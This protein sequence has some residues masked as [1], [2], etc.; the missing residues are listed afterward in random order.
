M[1]Q[2]QMILPRSLLH[3]REQFV[4]LIHERADEWLVFGGQFGEERFEI[5]IGTVAVIW[6]DRYPMLSESKP[7]TDR[8]YKEF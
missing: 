3:A 7:V 8:R 5:R 6:E 2:Q 1:T 4:V